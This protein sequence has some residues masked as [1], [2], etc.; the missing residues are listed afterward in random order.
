MQPVSLPRPD[1][2]VDDRT[3]V[4]GGTRL[5]MFTSPL[6]AGLVLSGLSIGTG[7]AIT[8]TSLAGFT[9]RFSTSGSCEYA[10]LSLN[11]E[12]DDEAVMSTS[13]QLT[14]IQHL[15]GLNTTELAQVIGVSRPTI[16]S[17]MRDDQEPHPSNLERMSM[18]YQFAR[19]WKRICPKSLGAFVRQPILGSQSLVQLLSEKEYDAIE[20]QGALQALAPLVLSKNSARIK[21]VLFDVPEEL[22]R[23]RLSE[24]FGM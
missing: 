24:E 4:N 17:W 11:R 21:P 16:Y 23:T 13:Q 1:L 22:Q 18:L 5:N 20:I 6:I 19:S 12:T 8:T 9:T 2:L 15:L 3:A 10:R 7:G 14:L